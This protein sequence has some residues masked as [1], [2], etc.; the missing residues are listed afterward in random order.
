MEGFRRYRNTFR[1][2]TIVCQIRIPDPVTLSVA[3][4]HP[5]SKLGLYMEGELP[6]RPWLTHRHTRAPEHGQEQDQGPELLRSV[7][8]NN[9]KK[10]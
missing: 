4:G 5:M 3:R 7:P 9:P 1:E 2:T 10:S 8:H 6:A